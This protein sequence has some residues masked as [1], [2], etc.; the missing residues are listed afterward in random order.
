V[1]TANRK[2]FNHTRRGF[3]KN[4]KLDLSYLLKELESLSAD[5]FAFALS[6]FDRAP[7]IKGYHLR[8]HRSMPIYLI[9]S[10]NVAGFGVAVAARDISS[11]SFD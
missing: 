2:I 7:P 6:S 1:E 11:I 4:E 8:L 9:E 3:L 10:L 5:A